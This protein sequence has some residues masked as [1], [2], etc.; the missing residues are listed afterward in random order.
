MARYHVALTALICYLVLS[1]GTGLAEANCKVKNESGKKMIIIPVD[2]DINI[3]VD[4]NATVELP[5]TQQKCNFMNPD[6][7]NKTGP[8]TLKDN[9]TYICGDGEVEG[10][11]DM[12]LA[13]SVLGILKLTVKVFVSL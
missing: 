3:E 10:T 13:V 12:Y 7:G 6:T 9:R 4:V 11:M 1:E 2:V 5:S 8:V